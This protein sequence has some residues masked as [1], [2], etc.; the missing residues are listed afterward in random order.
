MFDADRQGA[1][2]APCSQHQAGERIEGYVNQ[3]EDQDSHPDRTGEPQEAGRVQEGRESRMKSIRHEV[4]LSVVLG[5]FFSWTRVII[6][7][8]KAK[9]RYMDDAPDTRRW[10]GKIKDVWSASDEIRYKWLNTKVTEI[11]P[12]PGGTML[13]VIITE[14]DKY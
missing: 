14:E 1:D 7:D 12:L 5:L 3:G 2:S 10:T 6:E 13:F 9:D 8:R 4:A 11:R